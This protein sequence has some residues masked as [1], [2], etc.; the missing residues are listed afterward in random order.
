MTIRWTEEEY[1]MHMDQK[2]LSLQDA[3]SGLGLQEHLKPKTSKTSQN[4]TDKK[5]GKN[6]DT[7]K[8]ST[9]SS[10]KKQ[11]KK[12]KRGVETGPIFKSLSQCNPVSAWGE[13][14]LC[15]NM[16][17]GRVLTYNELFSILQYRKFE[18]FRYKKVCRDIIRRAVA[19][20]QTPKTPQP[21][22]DGP[23]RLT[24]LRVGTKEMDRD[25]LPVVFKYFTDTLKREKRVKDPNNTNPSIID[26]DNPNIIVDIVTIQSKGTPRLAML[27]E[28]VPQWEKEHVPM[29]DEWIKEKNA[30]LSA[31]APKPS[32]RKATQKT[33][34]VK[35]TK[36]Q[37][38]KAI[39][40]KSP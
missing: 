24:L 21:F 36:P 27:L 13:D 7:T 28:K 10:G 6:N 39:K 33:P 32:Q 35:K 19:N 11:E 12:K 20:T 1:K 15:I 16:D 34:S 25:A 3:L 37:K 40:K 18:A 2:N 22:F 26:D 31:S 9:K 8:S 14:W 30:D 17:G 5:N 23:T 29:W 38:L 4:K